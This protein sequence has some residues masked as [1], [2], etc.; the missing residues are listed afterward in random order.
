MKTKEAKLEFIKDICIMM[1]RI[2]ITLIVDKD[3]E[4]VEKYLFNKHHLNFN[5]CGGAGYCASTEVGNI[6]IWINKFDDSIRSYENFSH[7]CFHAIFRIMKE[8]GSE[9]TEE[10]EETFA[11]L[12]TYVF[13]YCLD[14]I[15]KSSYFKKITTKECLKTPPKK[16]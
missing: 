3:A 13:G 5:I 6:I 8:T 2:N 11:Y 10:G 1:Y 14:E 9:Y 16:H 12:F 7:E 4:K 15:K